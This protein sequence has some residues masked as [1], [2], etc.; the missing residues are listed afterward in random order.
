MEGGTE[1]LCWWT[2]MSGTLCG[3][4]CAVTPTSRVLCVTQGHADNTGPRQCLE[5]Q[6]H[7][8]PWKPSQGPGGGA[9]V[10]KGAAGCSLEGEQRG[11]S[12]LEREPMRTRGVRA[13]PAEGA[14]S[15]GGGR[16]GI[17]QP[18]G[19]PR[20]CSRV[21]GHLPQLMRQR[22]LRVGGGAGRPRRF[23]V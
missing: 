15:P 2:D 6:G 17:G 4:G 20:G 22:G 13:G 23:H 11:G 14:G 7:L 16:L 18:R 10:L 21:P 9:G 5:S 19:R 3:P 12:P 1:T 8:D